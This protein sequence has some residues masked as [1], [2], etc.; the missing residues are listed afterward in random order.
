MVGLGL[1]T[2][3][4]D[5]GVKTRPRNQLG[6]SSYNIYIFFFLFYHMF[7]LCYWL[8]NNPEAGELLVCVSAQKNW[9][10]GVTH[11]WPGLMPSREGEGK[12]T[13]RRDS[14]I[15]RLLIIVLSLSPPQRNLQGWLARLSMTRGGAVDPMCRLLVSTLTGDRYTAVPLLAFQRVGPLCRALCCEIIRTNNLVG[16]GSPCRDTLNVS[17]VS[18]GSIRTRLIYI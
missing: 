3:M 13:A 14:R 9:S 17:S 2:W 11:F 18:L 8:A 12:K 4:L 15:F 1:V 16:T 6:L 7:H 5:A 10:N